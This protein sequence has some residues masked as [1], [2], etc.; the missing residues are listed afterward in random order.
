MIF[1]KYR[2]EK[3][4][5]GSGVYDTHI[6]KVLSVGE[7]IDLLNKYEEQQEVIYALK[8]NNDIEYD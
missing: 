7:I 6:G 3:V 2:Y 1:P 4:D 8:H 5:Y